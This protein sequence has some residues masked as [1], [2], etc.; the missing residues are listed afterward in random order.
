MRG[1]SG[2]GESFKKGDN[3]QNDLQAA[4]LLEIIKQRRSTRAF[5]G[6]P[7]PRA[8]M[9]K[10]LEAAIWAPSGGNNQSWLFTAILNKEIIDTINELIRQGF[11]TW[12]PDDDYPGKLGAKKHSQ[13]DDFHFCNHAPALILASNQPPQGKPCGM[14]FCKVWILCVGLIPTITETFNIFFAATAGASPGVLNQRLRIK[15]F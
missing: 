8:D 13:R 7:V 10:L 2:R 15:N 9:E 3:M 11:Q 12:I 14:L 6:Q 1:A 4:S 5:S